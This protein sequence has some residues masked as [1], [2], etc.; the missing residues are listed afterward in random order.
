MLITS[1]R[2]ESIDNHSN[3]FFSAKQILFNDIEPCFNF[4]GSLK[5]FFKKNVV[6]FFKIVF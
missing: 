6:I 3:H 2:K 5:K 4:F 1:K